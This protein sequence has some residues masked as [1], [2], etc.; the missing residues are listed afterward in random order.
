MG[1]RSTPAD[2]LV[3]FD[4]QRYRPGMTDTEPLTPASRDDLELAIAFALQF[5]GRK[6]I[7]SAGE[8]MATIAAERIVAHLEEAGFV[9]MRKPPGVGAAALGR[10]YEPPEQE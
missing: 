6:R 8:I 7:R 5:R 10:G 4:R 2:V 1:D 9:I 3:S